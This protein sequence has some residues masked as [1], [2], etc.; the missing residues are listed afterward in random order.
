M[1]V[2]IRP[3]VP[4]DAE[5]VAGVHVRGWRDAYSHLL[6]A[7][8][9]DEGALQRRITQWRRIIDDADPA[10]TVRVAEVDGTVVGFAF[11]GPAAGEDAAREEELYAIYVDTERHGTGVGQG[12]LDAALAGRPAQLW[13]VTDNSRAQAFYRRNG[14]RADGAVKVEQHLDDLTDIRMVR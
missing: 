8:F 14:F 13:V 9:Y 12:L 1:T 11:A 4:R 10:Q 6:S 2:I 3:P 7:R 5:Q